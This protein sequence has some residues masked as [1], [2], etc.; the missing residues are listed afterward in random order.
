MRLSIALV[1]GLVLGVTGCA[2]KE[3]D[4]SGSS[5][6]MP[7]AAPEAPASAA[8]N[9]IWRNEAFV[10]H[11]HL[12]AERL[13][14]LN[15]AL[16]DGNLTEAK[17]SADWLAT[18]DSDSNIQS[19]WMPHLYRMRAEAEAVSAAPDIATAQA[20]ALRITGQCQECHAAVGIDTLLA[21]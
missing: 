9:E 5:G 10:Q 8:E 1:L 6:E 2:E 21:Q 12:H 15:F 14:E 19:D 4:S 13:D 11:M 20:A 18:H 16:A 17:A 3:Q 7:M